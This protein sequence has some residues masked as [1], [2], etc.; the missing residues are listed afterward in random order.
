MIPISA[1][2]RS[3]LGTHTSYIV[4]IMSNEFAYQVIPAGR[5]TP[6]DFA[7]VEQLV[8]A[9]GTGKPITQSSTARMRVNAE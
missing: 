6:G 3:R 4:E 9:W 2:C 1:L 8:A 7:E 5:A